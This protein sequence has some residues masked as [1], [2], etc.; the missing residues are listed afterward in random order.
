[1]R[2]I[3]IYQV[4]A[5]TN[6]PFKGNSAAVAMVHPRDLPL[7]DEDRQLIAA[8]NN[9]A[10][11][12]FVELFD[13]QSAFATAVEFNLRWFTPEIEVPLCG[14]ATLASA[15][16]LMY[17]L[18]NPATEITF[19]TLSGPLKVVR[20]PMEAGSPADERAA[21][22][23]SLPLV[24]PT[25]ELPVACHC[26]TCP[27]VNAL[28]PGLQVRDVRFASQLKYVLIICDNKRQDLEHMQPAISEAAS[29]S[30]NGEIV[31][32]IVSLMDGGTI[33]SRFF[34]PW[35]G[36]PEDPVTGSAHSVLAAY[37]C[38]EAGQNK[39]PARQCSKR[40]GDLQVTVHTESKMV[41]VSGHAVTTI[42]GTIFVPW[43][44]VPQ[45]A[46]QQ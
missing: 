27:L 38:A 45:S 18:G 21:L 4:D 19:N 16:C 3:P 37:Y 6:Q 15:A 36:I 9:L 32:V 14:H 5:F 11:T 2:S 24:D 41:D 33:C 31:G 7:T 35:A 8:E 17:D 39:M 13:T 26:T 12:A 40:G 10:E 30:R 43:S 20:G 34:A 46:R 29:C 23:M 1:M 44:I 42:A 25:D 22:I 28:C